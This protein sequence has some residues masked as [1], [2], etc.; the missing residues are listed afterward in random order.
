MAYLKFVGRA[1]ANKY[2]DSDSFHDLIAYITDPV[3]AVVVGTANLNSVETAAHEMETV[4]ACGRKSSGKKL[5]HIVI[6]FSPEELRA[7]SRNMVDEIARQCLQYF[8]NRYQVVYSVHAYPQEHI[9]IV[10]NRVSPIDFRR[11]PDRYEDREKF[12][13]FLWQILFHYNIRLW[14]N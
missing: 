1:D 2:K 12:W 7:H 3:K 11:Y 4:A 13:Q 5:C 9:H 8:A 10:V 6:A 14:K